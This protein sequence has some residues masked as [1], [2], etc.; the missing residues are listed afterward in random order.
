MAVHAGSVLERGGQGLR[1][2][3]HLFEC[4]NVIIQQGKQCASCH[5]SYT[6]LSG[7]V[8]AFGIIKKSLLQ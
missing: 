8:Q 6:N 7:V 4:L 5:Q 1:A 2:L 3:G